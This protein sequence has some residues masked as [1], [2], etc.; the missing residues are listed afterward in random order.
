MRLPPKLTRIIYLAGFFAFS[1]IPLAHLCASPNDEEEFVKIEKIVISGSRFEP[2]SIEM[3]MGIRIG[4]QMNEPVLRKAI[5]RMLDSGLIKNVDYSY[6]S[7]SAPTSVDLELKIEDELPL[8]PA[9]IELPDIEAEDVW[10]YLRNVDPLFTRELPRTQKALQFYA[11]YI[12]RY[13][14]NQRKPMRVSSVITADTE[15]NARGIVFVP[16]N[17]LGTPQFKK[18]Q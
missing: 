5:S 6:M 12:E 3:L 16:A 18:R 17:L 1:A 4:Q 11:R 7:A 10:S 2:R 14:A 13:L 9:T 15:G 8:L